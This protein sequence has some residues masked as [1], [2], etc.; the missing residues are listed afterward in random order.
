MK[1]VILAVALLAFTS[2]ASA[3]E[4]G[5]LWDW[6]HGTNGG[7]RQAG[8]ISVGSK[9]GALDPSLAKVGIQATAER[10]T[11][12]VL[13]VNRYTAKASY[14]VFTFAGVTTNVHAGAAYIDPQSGK[15]ANGFAGLAGF[16]FAYPVTQKVSL[17]ADYDYQKSNA[18]VKSFNGN[19][20][21][22]GI[23]YSF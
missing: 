18:A 10:S 3:V 17:T 1:K 2:L 6:G 13:N 5:A 19:V 22:T 16:G 14:D 9:L 20:I 11:S 4:V 12:G 7:T 8:G 21:T 23:K 15:I